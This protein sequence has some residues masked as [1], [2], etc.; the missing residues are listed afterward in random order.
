MR[1]SALD[2]DEPL[3]LFPPTCQRPRRLPCCRA[4]RITEVAPMDFAVAMGIAA[5]PAGTKVVRAALEI[6]RQVADVGGV[7]GSIS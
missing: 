3:W 2:P 6:D 4:G 7:L 5:D 1:A